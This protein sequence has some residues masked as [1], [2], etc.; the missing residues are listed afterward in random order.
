MKYAAF[1]SRLK[2]VK[3]FRP[4]NDLAVG[5]CQ[6]VLVAMARQVQVPARRSKKD[7]DQIDEVRFALCTTKDRLNSRQS[8]YALKP[9]AFRHIID[10]IPCAF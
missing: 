7:L 10:E 8:K 9:F 1:N 6:T 2:D 4:R 3:E 5:E